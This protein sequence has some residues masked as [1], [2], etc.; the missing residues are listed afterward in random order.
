MILKVLGYISMV[1]FLSVSIFIWT[2]WGSIL[3]Y[4]LFP[5]P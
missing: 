2:L 5:F 1:F 4:A 3:I